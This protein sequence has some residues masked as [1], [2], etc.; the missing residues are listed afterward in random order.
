MAVDLYLL[1]QKLISAARGNIEPQELS[2][3]FTYELAT[4]PPSLFGMDTLIRAANKPQLETTDSIVVFDGYTEMPSTIDTAHIRRSKG[5]VDNMVKFSND[6]T[7]GMK[8]DVFLANP[9][10]K[11][12]FINNLRE[13]FVRE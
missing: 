5:K 8:K 2:T 13:F 10:N 3:L 1:F 12:K 9:Q 6:M 11:Q 7:L 4:H